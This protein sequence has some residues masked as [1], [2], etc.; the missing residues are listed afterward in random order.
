MAPPPQQNNN[1]HQNPHGAAGAGATSEDWKDTYGAKD[2]TEFGQE[3]HG[4]TRDIADEKNGGGYVHKHAQNKSEADVVVTNSDLNQPMTASDSNQWRLLAAKVFANG[5]LQEADLTGADVSDFRLKIDD[6][7]ADRW[8]NLKSY[9][10]TRSEHKYGEKLEPHQPVG[11]RKSTGAAVMGVDFHENTI[12][13]GVLL[14]KGTSDQIKEVLQETYY[15]SKTVFHV[16]R[17]LN[18]HIHER[19]NA[20]AEDVTS[21][22]NVK[23]DYHDYRQES[24]PLFQELV[25]SGAT[26]GNQYQALVGTKDGDGQRDIPPF[27]L[28]PAEAV[29]EQDLSY[30]QQHGGRDL[31]WRAAQELIS[32]SGRVDAIGD[33]FPGTANEQKR[34]SALATLVGDSGATH[35]QADSYKVHVH[36]YAK[37][38]FKIADIAENQDPDLRKRGMLVDELHDLR[39]NNTLEK[40]EITGFLQDHEA[41]FQEKGNVRDLPA[42]DYFIAKNANGEKYLIPVDEKVVEE[43]TVKWG[44]KA[45]E[46]D[47]M[48][49]AELRFE[50]W[51]ED[52]HNIGYRTEGGKVSPATTKKINI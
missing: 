36:V 40:L 24:V 46:I 30:T 12:D 29:K 39:N 9:I 51:L 14:L 2:G 25:G 50:R 5:S 13:L 6:P 33:E 11:V 18:Q 37:E 45:G 16:D 8:S 1:A 22:T 47:R 23:F 42:A 17:N 31:V 35:D 21:V 44:D 48:K 43:V 41:S 19:L 4:Y 27:A 26:L 32:H 3:I 10:E 15:N 20:M 49:D 7:G 38:G 52:A 34:D 28:K